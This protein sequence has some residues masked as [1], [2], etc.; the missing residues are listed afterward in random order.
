SLKGQSQS[1][2]RRY[3]HEDIGF[4]YRMTNICAAIGYAQ[5]ERLPAIL[6]RKRAIAALYRAALADAPVTFQARG[7]NHESSEWLVSRLLPEWV[8]RD[9][10][11]SQLEGVNIETRPVSHCAH[12]M[13][14]YAASLDLPVAERISRLGLSLPS[15]PQ[16]SD[17]DVVRV[18]Q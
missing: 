4:N 17:A 13:P 18:A 12:H 1:A 10:M 6:A 11:M 2:T 14:M 9:V 3:W 15:Y 16:M 8:T 7:A 5:T